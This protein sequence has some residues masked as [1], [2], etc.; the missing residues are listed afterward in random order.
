LAC[1]YGAQIVMA[2]SSGPLEWRDAANDF[3]PPRAS[4]LISER[5]LSL[6]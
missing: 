5:N 2:N 4:G 1:E 3:L 6:A